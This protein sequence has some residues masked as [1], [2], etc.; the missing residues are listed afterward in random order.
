MKTVT[1]LVVKEE[2]SYIAE[3]GKKFLDKAECMRHEEQLAMVDLKA[4]LD[5][6]ECCKEA[7]GDTPLEGC[8]HMEYHGYYW[9]RPKTREEATV[10]YKWYKLEYELLDAEIGQWICI[11]ECDD[12][13][14]AYALPCSLRH[15]KEFLGKF[16][17]DVLITKKEEDCNV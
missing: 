13:C 9:Y 11:E 1:T 8:E 2:T 15:I 10:L 5:Q 3:D 12:C 14:W 4:K 16:G 17:Y 7:E 6:I